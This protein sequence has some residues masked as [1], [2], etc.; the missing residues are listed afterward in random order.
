MSISQI[1]ALFTCPCAVKFGFRELGLFHNTTQDSSQWHSF[2]RSTQR[3]ISQFFLV[4]TTGA[5]CSGVAICLSCRIRW[6]RWHG[7]VAPRPCTTRNKNGSPQMVTARATYQRLWRSSPSD[8]HSAIVYCQAQPANVNR[9][10]VNR[11]KASKRSNLGLVRRQQRLLKRIAPAQTHQ[12]TFAFAA[13]V[14]YQSI[15]KRGHATCTQLQ[16]KHFSF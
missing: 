14:R 2:T 6:C 11:S 13:A 12:H 4:C 5:V 10:N 7:V 1:C 8:K 15:D 16:Q 3:S 9:G